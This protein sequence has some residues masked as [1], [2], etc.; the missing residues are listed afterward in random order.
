M[1]AILYRLTAVLGAAILIYMP[2]ATTAATVSSLLT[3]NKK[4]AVGQVHC[5]S[6]VQ[7]TPQNVPLISSAPS[8]Y[9][10]AQLHTAYGVPAK[11]AKP[12]MVA[13]VGAYHDPSAASDLR[14]YDAA[15]SL[16]D[17]PQLQQI[18]QRGSK[19]LPATDAGWALE[20]SLD[21]ETVHEMCQNCS[22]L[23]VEADSPT[24]ANLMAAVDTAVAKG[25]TVI[26]NSYGGSE[27]AS[28]VRSNSHLAHAG[29]TVVASAGDSGY[30]VEYPAAS[31]GVVA[32]GGTTL[33]LTAAGSRSSETA[34]VDGGS[35]C[36]K[37]ES[38]PNWQRDSGCT[39][40]TV[41]DVAADADPA[42]GAAIYDSTSYQ[43]HKGWFVLG[44]TSLSAPLIAGIYGLA[45]SGS[46]PSILYQHRNALY[47]ITSGRNGSC[48]TY[49]CAGGIGYDGPTGLGSPL[50][51]T[52][53]R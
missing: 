4:V 26:S 28:D 37:V 17:P 6:S 36:S 44:G 27:S 15:F 42:T 10:P 40:R 5:D 1:N 34:W 8:G 20:E 16:P 31:P 24:T 52:A 21:M 45:G 53:F 32:A 30:G 39:G 22:L 19:D 48:K 50:G 18:S 25:A 13:V 33:H 29:V 35:G 46:G 14:T 47:D 51:L 2:S 11:A 7:V 12:V 41:A 43:S 23:L 3:C 38:K 49:L 9:G